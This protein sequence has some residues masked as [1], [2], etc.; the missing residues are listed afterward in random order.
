MADRQTATYLMRRF[1][2]A[3][4]RPVSRRGQNFLVDLNLLGL[5]VETAQVGRNEVAL[6]IGTGLG[7]LTALLSQRAAAVVTVEVDR[8]LHRLAAEQ[9][10]EMDNVTMLQQDALRNKNSLD[11][12][13]LD[14]VRGTMAERQAAG[15]KLVANLPYNIAT[16]VV[17]NLLL[18]DPVPISMTVT[19][20]KELADRMTA[21]PG[22]KDYGAL[23]AWMQTQCDVRVVRVMPPSAFWPRPR[24]WSAIVHVIPQRDRWNT[25]SDRRFFHTF[26]RSLFLHRRKY[27]RACLI[28]ACGGKL[29]KADID[30][31]LRSQGLGEQVRAEDLSPEVLLQLARASEQLQLERATR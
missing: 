1:E 4:L 21:R 23:S 17:S 22:T 10:A 29:S 8:D 15:F 11:A 14:A 31:L 28:S 7:S 5:L 3:G 19:I 12:R 2:M 9:L 24:V 20:Q 6:E 25:G 13:V 16:P 27:L 26:V 30:Q 18:T